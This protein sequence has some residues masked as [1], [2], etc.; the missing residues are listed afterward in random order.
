MAVQ[1]HQ[2]QGHTYEHEEQ[3][4][5]VHVEPLTDQTK[6]QGHHTK[7]LRSPSGAGQA[8]NDAV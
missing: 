5:E 1:L 7:R 8:E 4:T 2:D 6:R 3:T